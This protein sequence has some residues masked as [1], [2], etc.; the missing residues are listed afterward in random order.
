M[1]LD[2][3]TGNL[4]GKHRVI[5][6]IN[7]CQVKL[8]RG[9]KDFF[10]ESFIFKCALGTVSPEWRHCPKGNGIIIFLR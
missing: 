4:Q 1:I 2:Q 3:G 7:N 10:R 8:I 5:V 9:D 6:R